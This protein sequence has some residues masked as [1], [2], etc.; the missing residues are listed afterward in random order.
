M[1]IE[2]VIQLIENTFWVH[3]PYIDIDE[4]E[5]LAQFPEPMRSIIVDHATATHYYWD[6]TEYEIEF[7]ILIE[8]FVNT[9]DYK[10]VR[11]EYEQVFDSP[12]YDLYVMSFVIQ[13]AEGNLHYSFHN[14]YERG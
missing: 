6:R 8:E 7:D 9:F 2:Q 5:D 12:G 3:G 4:E 10:I 1:T 13:D 11:M 14:Q